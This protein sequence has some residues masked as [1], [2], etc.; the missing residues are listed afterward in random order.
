MEVFVLTCKAEKVIPK[1]ICVANV[2]RYTTRRIWYLVPSVA[3]H[4]T[5]LRIIQSFLIID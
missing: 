1:N 5:H 3:Y 2:K 4:F